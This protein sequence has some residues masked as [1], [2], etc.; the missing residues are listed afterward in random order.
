MIGNS[1]VCSAIKL[2]LPLCLSGRLRS[3][4]VLGKEKAMFQ[5]QTTLRGFVA[6]ASDVSTDVL[7]SAPNDLSKTVT[8][9][10]NMGDVYELTIPSHTE[11]LEPIRSFVA[12]ISQKAG[13][14]ETAVIDIEVAVEQACVKA[15]KHLQTK[16]ESKRLHLRITIDNQ[17]LTVAVSDQ[18]QGFYHKQYKKRNARRLLSRLQQGDCGVLLMILVMDQ[19]YFASERRKGTQVRL[20]KYRTP[21]ASQAIH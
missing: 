19:V 6:N 21:P 7:A 2:H 11:N 13:F 14:D 18:G 10:A 8:G 17:K 9:L 5:N 1:D 16:D 20:V 3:S 12:T 15:I 4:Y